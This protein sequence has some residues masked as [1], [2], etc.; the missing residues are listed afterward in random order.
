MSASDPTPPTAA[1]NPAV[2]TTFGLGP[3]WRTFD[4]FLF[5][6][7][8]L[9]DYPQGDGSLGPNA[10][11]HG[12]QIG[13][14]F[15]GIDGW[16][17]YH[18]DHVPG[19]PSHPHRGFETVTYVRT[20][21][22]DHSDSLGARARFGK[23]DTQWLTAGKG[24]V[25]SEMFPLINTD[26]P[27]PLE[28]FQIWLNLP[29][30]SKMVEPYFT[31]FWADD[32]PAVTL[33]ADASPAGDTALVSDTGEGES[34]SVEAQ[35][36]VSVT[37]VAG[38]AFGAVPLDPPPDSWASHPESDIAIWHI[39]LS[40][41]SSLTLPPAASPDTVRT[42]YFFHGPELNVE[43]GDQRYALG[44][45]TAAVVDSGPGI[46]LESGD[47]PAEVL[48]L[49]GRPLNEPVAQ[50]GPFVMNTQAEIQQAFSDYQRTGFGGWPWDSSGPTHGAGWRRFAEVVPP[51][52]R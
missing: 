23:G 52:E 1:E 48:V 9:D 21:V 31:M 6:A 28:L 41:R 34:S 25:H 33:G 35:G 47:D 18:G 51:G 20:G 30:R 39:V 26:E 50:Y 49:Q 15:A 2:I 19:F 32:T 5:C 13:Q 3:Q 24:I 43:R 38:S 7:H 22:I 37:V 11:L 8:H 17:M 36:S 46:R 42:V 14:D 4:P 10:S 16:N 44:A 29:A 45:S 40:P 12:R 27:N